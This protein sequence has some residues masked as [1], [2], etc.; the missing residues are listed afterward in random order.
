MD[1]VDFGT[2]DNRKEKVL[3]VVV[4]GCVKVKSE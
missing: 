4:L 1:E 3:I 2:D